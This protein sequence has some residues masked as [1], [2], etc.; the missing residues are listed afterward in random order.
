MS[1]PKGSLLKDIEEAKVTTGR[2]SAI[3]IVLSKLEGDDKKDF[4]TAVDDWTISASAI[5]RALRKRGIH[6]DAGNIRA[7]RRGEVNRVS[8]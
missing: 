2:K 4:I 6:L 7:Y 1:K 3:A 8:L 5:T